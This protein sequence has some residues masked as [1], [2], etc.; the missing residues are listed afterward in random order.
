MQSRAT[1]MFASAL[2]LEARHWHVAP[3]LQSESLKHSS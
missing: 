3:P 1:H 2:E